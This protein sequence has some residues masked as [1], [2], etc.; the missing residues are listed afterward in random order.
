MIKSRIFEKLKKKF[1]KLKNI[2][3]W[4][5]SK[6]HNSVHFQDFCLIFDTKWSHC[7]ELPGNIFL[8][9]IQLFVAG[10]KPPDFSIYHT[11]E[12]LFWALFGL[13]DLT[14]FRLKEDHFLSEWTGK[15]IFGSYCCCSIIVLLNMLIA[16]MSNSYQYISDQADIEW[17]FARSRLFLG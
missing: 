12:T 15:T 14:H 9:T 10:P 4:K 17:K 3:F 11:A 16:M 1:E 2:N 7:S 5:I 8:K 13:V 6:I